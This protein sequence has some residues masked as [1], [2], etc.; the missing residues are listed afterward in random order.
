[1]HHNAGINIISIIIKIPEQ[2]PANKSPDH[3]FGSKMT[4]HKYDYWYYDCKSSAKM[5]TADILKNPSEK[6]SSA[7]APIIENIES[8]KRL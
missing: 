1:M 6:I 8:N 7:I 4:N 5:R 3:R 2:K